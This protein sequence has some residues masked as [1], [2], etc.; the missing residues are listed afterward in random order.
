M[1]LTNNEI[2]VKNL[3]KTSKQALKTNKWSSF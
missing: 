1:I 3:N 2:T